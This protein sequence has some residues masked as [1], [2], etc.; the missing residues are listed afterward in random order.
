MLKDNNLVAVYGSL[1]KGLGNHGVLGDSEYMFN[2]VTKG[3]MY[4]YSGG[5]F[6][7]V[8][9]R[10]DTSLVVEVYRVPDEDTADRLDWLEGY[11]N[12]YNRTQVDITDADGTFI[13]E[14]WLY[15]IEDDMSH[16]PLVEGGDWKE[17]KLN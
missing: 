1:R 10:G 6:P 13:C 14:A 12:F 15:H 11:P 5:G 9:L 16:L 3:T 2:G 8:T 7:A 4:D 17:Y